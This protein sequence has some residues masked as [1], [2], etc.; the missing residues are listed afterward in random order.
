MNRDRWIDSR[1][2]DDYFEALEEART[3]GEDEGEPETALPQSAIDAPA[4]SPDN[5]LG[6]DE[7]LPF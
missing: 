2:A 5:N 6:D 1:D 7:D 4:G 3:L